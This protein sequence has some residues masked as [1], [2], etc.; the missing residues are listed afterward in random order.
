VDIYLV[1]TE[2]AEG[3]EAMEGAE[4]REGEAERRGELCEEV[5]FLSITEKNMLTIQQKYLN[6]L[7]YAFVFVT[8]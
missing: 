4:D 1:M 3:V 7:C 5:S 8:G 6:K 2:L